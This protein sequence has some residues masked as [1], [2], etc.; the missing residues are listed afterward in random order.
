MTVF[1]T[2]CQ[3]RGCLARVAFSFDRLSQV[4]VCR[5]PRR[6]TAW[7]WL[8]HRVSYDKGRPTVPTTRSTE[9]VRIDGGR[10]NLT[11]PMLDRPGRPFWGCN[12]GRGQIKDILSIR[13][14]PPPSNL[15]TW[16]MGKR[17]ILDRHSDLSTWPTAKASPLQSELCSRSTAKGRE[18]LFGCRSPG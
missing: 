2:A 4:F 1:Q 16:R 3:W 17:M 18:R 10:T 14:R 13:E 7:R 15:S 11:P 12:D 9:A 8:V 6:S 5:S